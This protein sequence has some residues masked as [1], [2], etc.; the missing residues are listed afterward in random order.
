MPVVDVLGPWLHGDQGALWAH[1]NTMISALDLR[2][3]QQ[4][5]GYFSFFA[6]CWSHQQR[7]F[8]VFICLCCSCASRVAIVVVVAVVHTEVVVVVVVV[9]TA[10][11]VMVAVDDEIVCWGGSA[12]AGPAAGLAV[13]FEAQ[14]FLTA[15]TKEIDCHCILLTQTAS[16]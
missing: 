13:F 15:G 1:V 11:V 4:T 14:T 5:S 16:Q 10:V 2:A 6:C 7:S 8:C 3:R 9:S 12:V